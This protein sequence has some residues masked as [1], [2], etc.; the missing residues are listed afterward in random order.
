ME[1]GNVAGTTRRKLEI[2]VELL[3][4]IVPRDT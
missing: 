1:R 2:L 3:F 4:S